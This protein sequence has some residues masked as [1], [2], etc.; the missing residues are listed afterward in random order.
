MF[1]QQSS[2]STR[3][4]DNPPVESQ[5]KPEPP[6]P[7]FDGMTELFKQPSITN[8]SSNTVKPTE[9]PVPA[10]NSPT[11]QRLAEPQVHLMEG[12][13]ISISQDDKVHEVAQ[14]YTKTEKP[15][16]LVVDGDKHVVEVRQVWEE[17][18]DDGEWQV[19]REEQALITKKADA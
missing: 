1:S 7:K 19:V 10:P 13:H 18:L 2:L 9:F 5:P 11:S 16:D 6:T 3:P 17:R 8:L 12:T 4:A 14:A 15:L